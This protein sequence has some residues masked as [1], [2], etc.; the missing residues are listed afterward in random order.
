MIKIKTTSKLCINSITRAILLAMFTI[1][2]GSLAQTLPIPP[3]GGSNQYAASEE[4]FGPTLPN[5]SRTRNKVFYCD[6]CG[7]WRTTFN[8]CTGCT[9]DSLPPTVNL[10]YIQGRWVS[11]RTSRSGCF[12]AETE[13]QARGM[14]PGTVFGV[15]LTSRSQ[16]QFCFK[17][18]EESTSCRF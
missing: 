7:F 13:A 14:I 1:Q 17:W 8:L 6:L 5:C 18:E 3:T 10:G 15:S 12:T 4:R 2:T 9:K 16:G 11:E